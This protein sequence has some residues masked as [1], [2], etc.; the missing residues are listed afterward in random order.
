MSKITL[1]NDDGSTVEFTQVVSQEVVP[2]VVAPVEVA[3]DEQV[4]T[5]AND[6]ATG[7]E[8]APSQTETP[9]VAP[10]ATGESV[11]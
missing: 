3:N 5:P 9:E 10:E 2:D 7:T 6:Q 11:A 1:T 8:V 4:T